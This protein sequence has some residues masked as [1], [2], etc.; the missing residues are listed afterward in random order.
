MRHN[1]TEMER[2]MKTRRKELDILSEE[3]TKAELATRRYKTALESTR[4]A[5]QGVM[6]NIGELLEDD[7]KSEKKA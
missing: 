3:K 4:T 5:L 1:F 6:G 2:E 7:K